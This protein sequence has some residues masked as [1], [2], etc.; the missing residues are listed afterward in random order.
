MEGV[1]YLPLRRISFSLLHQ[2]KLQISGNMPKKRL[3]HTEEHN[4]TQSRTHQTYD[5]SIMT[6]RDFLHYP[7]MH[8]LEDHHSYLHENNNEQ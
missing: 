4:E 8:K 2:D 6:N 7:E 5:I 1:I 3:R